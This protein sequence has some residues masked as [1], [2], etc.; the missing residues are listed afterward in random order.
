MRYPEVDP[1]GWLALPSGDHEWPHQGVMLNHFGT[2][3]FDHPEFMDREFLLQLDYFRECC[4][5]AV[6]VL[7]D[8]RTM[9][10]QR[11]LYRKEIR[12]EEE[13]GLPEG[14]LWPSDS[15]HL[16]IHADDLMIEHFAAAVDARPLHPTEERQLLFD[17]LI[18]E[19]HRKGIWPLLGKGTYD[20]HWHIDNTARLSGRRPAFWTGMSK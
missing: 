5:F 6:K 10:E 16:V 4:G 13:R 18:V 17:W 20:S 12:K 9:E 11:A 1:E 8:A 15:S 3:E 14:T 19:F 7:D 2:D